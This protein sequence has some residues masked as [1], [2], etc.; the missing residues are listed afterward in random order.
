MLDEARRGQGSVVARPAR[1]CTF[2]PSRSDFVR[3]DGNSCRVGLIREVSVRRVLRSRVAVALVVLGVGLAVAGGFSYAAIPGSTSGL[4]TACYPTSGTNKGV[5]RVIDAQAGQVCG[6]GN[7]TLSWQKSGL[8]WKGAWTATTAYFANDIVTYG[9]SRQVFVAIAASTG[10][11]PADAG[12]YWRVLGGGTAM[13]ASQVGDAALG[14][15]PE[16]TGDHHC[17]QRPVRGGVRRDQHLGHQRPLEHRVEDQPGDE[18]CHGDRRC[19]HEPGGGGVRR[20]Q[21]LGHQRWLEQR[22]ED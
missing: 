20:R 12:L 22:F 16:P 5:L 21:H 8:R 14:P 11:R 1:S 15:R 10:K 7:A 19:G 2:V 4:I 3:G 17:R 13:T 18:R 6:A 9:R